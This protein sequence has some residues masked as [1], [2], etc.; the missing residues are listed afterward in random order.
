MSYTYGEKG[1]KGIENNRNYKTGKQNVVA[2]LQIDNKGGRQTYAVLQLGVNLPSPLL[3]DTR[4][5]ERTH[6]ESCHNI[7]T[8]MR[9]FYN[10]CPTMILSCVKFI[11]ETWREKVF[12]AT[13]KSVFEIYRLQSLIL[14][15]RLAMLT[16]LYRNI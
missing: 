12:L 2:C 6:L 13:N 14:I 8:V 5:S 11:Y 16:F 7:S 9:L 1:R 3:P 10:P 4:R 15:F